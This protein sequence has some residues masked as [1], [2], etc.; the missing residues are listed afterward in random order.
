MLSSLL[1][2]QFQN[3]LEWNILAFNLR[4]IIITRRLQSPVTVSNRPRRPD[5]QLDRWNEG[6]I[7]NQTDEWTY[8]ERQEDR[9]TDRQTDRQAG[10]V[11]EW[12]YIWMD[13]QT[14]R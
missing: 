4:V 12:T 14:S 2:A 9:Q 13:S 8:M 7:D 6:Q 1:F 10:Q 11:G 5:R 3:I